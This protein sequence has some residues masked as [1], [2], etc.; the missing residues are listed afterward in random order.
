M[1][2]I[3]VPTPIINLQSGVP[4][5][6]GI[7]NRL[8]RCKFRIVRI[9]RHRNQCLQYCL[10]AFYPDINYIKKATI[11]WSCV[12]WSKPGIYML[13]DNAFVFNKMLGYNTAIYDDIDKN[14]NLIG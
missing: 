4:N 2:M 14:G 1:K 6:V 12:H 9:S 13:N 10:N 5:N 7:I 8:H 11:L 3:S